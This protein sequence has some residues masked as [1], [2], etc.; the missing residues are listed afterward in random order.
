MARPGDA[1][2]VTKGA[3][4]EATALFAATFPDRLAEGIG[5]DMVKRADAL[6]ERMTVVPEVIVARTFGVRDEGVTSM[7]D[8]TEGGV[9][10]AE[11]GDVWGLRS[12]GLPAGRIVC[13][14]ARVDLPGL[15][16]AGTDGAGLF[17]STNAGFGWSA[18]S[19]ISGTISD[20]TANAGGGFFAATASGVFHSTDDGASWSPAGL[21]GLDIRTITC[22]TQN[23]WLFAG[24]AG[25]GMARSTNDGDCGSGMRRGT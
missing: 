4:I 7:H 18:A 24:I 22:Q 17:R 5:A 13:L 6:F 15:V 12:A 19:G 21:A 9:F 8:A 25:M 14:F 23:G 20:L 3:A 2:V 10:G 1:V 16:L 11:D